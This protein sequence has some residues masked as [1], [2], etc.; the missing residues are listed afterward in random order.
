[1]IRVKTSLV[2]DACDSLSRGS[3]PSA[4]AL[5]AARRMD[6]RSL[7]RFARPL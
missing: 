2:G 5:R 4:A 3:S 6:R 1:M 7:A